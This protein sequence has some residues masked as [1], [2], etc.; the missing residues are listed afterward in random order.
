MLKPATCIRFCLFD[1]NVGRSRPM[2]V[3]HSC[4][5]QLSRTHGRRGCTRRV[6]QCSLSCADIEH[7]ALVDLADKYLI[8]APAGVAAAA[9]KGAKP[10]YTGGQSLIKTHEGSVAHVA[11]ALPAPALGEKGVYALGVL[12]SLLGGTGPHSG[13]AGQLQL[14]WHRQSRLARSVHNDA[15]SFIRSIAAF[16]FPYTDAGLLGLAGSCADH[17]SGRLVH[18]MVAFLKDA[19]SVQA[20]GPELSRAKKAFKLAVALDVESRAGARDDLGKQTLL[21]G[22]HASLAETFAA[23]DAVTAADVAGVAAA[24]L[25]APPSIAAV[26]SLVTV[27]RYD[28]LANLL[29]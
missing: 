2:T 8:S 9:S 5:D 27:P 3:R 26:G 28:M 19:A 20:T 13:G 10:V 4:A 11:L 1:D 22:K 16:A 25:K 24:A 17:E 15:H 14:G 6:A 12:Q 18:A 21:T 29:K 23:I 7:S